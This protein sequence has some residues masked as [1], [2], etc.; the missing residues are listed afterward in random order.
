MQ[1]VYVDTLFLINF[2]MDFISLWFSG[3]LMHLKR[4]KGPLLLASL[5]GGIYGCAASVLSGNHTVTVLIGLL[6]SFLLC[7]VAYRERMP[8]RRFACLCALFYGISLLFGGMLTAFYQLLFRFFTDKPDLYQLLSGGDAKAF[9]FFAAVLAAISVIGLAERFFSVDKSARS[10]GVCIR[11]GRKKITLT[12]LLDSGNTL[13]DPL[14]GK[15]AIVVNARAVE[16][17][18]PRD[19][20]SLARSGSLDPGRLA[21]ESR[22]RIRIVPAESLGGRQLLVGY[23]PDSVELIGE[24]ESYAADAMLV[25]A[26]GGEASFNGFSAIVPSALVL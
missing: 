5:F 7:F 1:V 11:S 16:G 10:V 24:K 19:V 14:S 4:K 9:F 6:S 25:I 12:G 23:I 20:L 21:G 2:C 13:R 26:G 17:V 3:K 8:K 22:R 15:A 18:L